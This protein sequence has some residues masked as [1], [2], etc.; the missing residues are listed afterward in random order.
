MLSYSSF[1]SFA[2]GAVRG[3]EAMADVLWAVIN[4]EE[5]LIP[6]IMA[7]VSDLN[8]H[9]MD[10]VIDLARKSFQTDDGRIELLSVYAQHRY[11][12]GYRTDDIAMWRSWMAYNA[13]VSIGPLPRRDDFSV[14][15]YSYKYAK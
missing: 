14:A 15:S 12:A 8:L 5:D 2:R 1:A 13:G 6:D 3:S 9:G 7:R 4:E 11:D 10:R